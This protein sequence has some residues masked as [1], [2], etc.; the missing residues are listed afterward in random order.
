MKTTITESQLKKIILESTKKAISENYS[1]YANISQ[2]TQQGG[3]SA[4]YVGRQ[5][6]WVQQETMPGEVGIL[7]TQD[8]IDKENANTQQSLQVWNSLGMA[9][10]L[11]E[12]QKLLGLPANE[13]DGKLGPQTLG[14]LLL[15]LGSG[16]TITTPKGGIAVD[17]LK[18]ANFAYGKR[19]TYQQINRTSSVGRPNNGTN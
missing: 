13:C 17:S 2:N 9:G 19:G 7:P 5:N 3:K 10:Q 16:K 8:E 11:A 18:T 14:K 6:G 15:A 4:G 1:G 12:I